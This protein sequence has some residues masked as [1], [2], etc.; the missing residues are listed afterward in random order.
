MEFRSRDIFD[1]KQ[2]REKLR[3][4][5]LR[6]FKEMCEKKQ[7]ININNNAVHLSDINAN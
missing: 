2:K 1:I 6:N 4:K 7:K 5:L 3:A